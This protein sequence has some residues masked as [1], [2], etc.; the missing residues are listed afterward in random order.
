MLNYCLLALA[1]LSCVLA[2]L[3]HATVHWLILKGQRKQ[4]TMIP[5]SVLKPLKGLD[6]DLYENLASFCRQVHPCFEIIFGAAD[7]S[8]PALAVARRVAA[9]HPHVPIRIIA[10]ECPTGLNPK[11]RLL[12]ALI[13]GAKYDAILISDS[14]V[15]V[16][17]HYLSTTAAELADPEVG[18][19][20][21]PIIGTGGNRLGAAFE[22]L[23]LNSYV[24]FG[25]ALANYVGR[26]A[27]VVGKS[28]LLRR[29]ALRQIGGLGRFAD[30]LAEDYL[31]GRAMRQ[32]GIR[33]VTCPSAIHSV[34]KTWNLQKTWQ[35]HVRWAQIRRSL[36]APGYLLELLLVPQ[37]WLALAAG[38]LLTQLIPWRS[39]AI[40]LCGYAYILV[41][42]SEALTILRWSKGQAR[43][44]VLVPFVGVRQL[45]QIALWVL[46][47]TKN[48]VEWRGEKL[49]IGKG[50]RLTGK[51][52]LSQ[53]VP[54]PVSRQAA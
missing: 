4:S 1:A 10:G 49:H 14:N 19:V 37:L 44:A 30:V 43:V 15:R 35:R 52:R 7:R 36:G 31:I 21:N 38:V 28:M 41:S 42:L 51:L 26:F 48:E 12:R 54:Q 9:A 23:L 53:P 18:L 20:S 11:V 3:S 17:P 8:D 33:V 47:C 32:R 46:A 5:V 39:T 45:A 6:D 13:R 24:I 22:N 50:S 34:N 40:G 16:D 2:L 29:S 25:L 27:C